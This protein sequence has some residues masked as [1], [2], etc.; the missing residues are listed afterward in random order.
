[1]G[2]ETP[3]H[4]IYEGADDGRVDPAEDDDISEPIEEG[5]PQEVLDG[6][7]EAEVLLPLGNTHGTG[8][9][10]WRKHDQ[11]GNLHGTANTNSILDSRTYEVELPNGEMCEYSANVIGE[12]MFAQCDYEGNQFLLMDAI[13]D[14][15]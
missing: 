3:T 12:N 14:N 9:V 13:V 10:K 11:E 5:V 6:Y 7:I 4:D 8:K 2:A 15:Q 1:M